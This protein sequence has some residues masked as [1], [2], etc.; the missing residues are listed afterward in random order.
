[1]GPTLKASRRSRAGFAGDCVKGAGFTDRQSW[2]RML[3][4]VAPCKI[5]VGCRDVFAFGKHS[6]CKL[7]A[8]FRP[9]AADAV[10][11]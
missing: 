4:E 7:Q 6:S 5:G 9:R 11:G 1:M 3:S 8:Q 2:L 10:H